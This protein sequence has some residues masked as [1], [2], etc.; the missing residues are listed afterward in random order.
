MDCPRRT[1]N[2]LNTW[3]LHGFS[4]GIFMRHLVVLALAV[5]LLF[6]GMFFGKRFGP[7]LIGNQGQEPPIVPPGP[8]GGDLPYPT[9]PSRLVRWCRIFTAPWTPSLIRWPDYAYLQIGEPICPS[10]A[11]KRAISKTSRCNAT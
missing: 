7:A 4:L 5:I 10:R 1:K 2:T 8:S 11:L 6:A 9:S 3:S